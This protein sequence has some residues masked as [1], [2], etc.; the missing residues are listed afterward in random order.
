MKIEV[1]LPTSFVPN[2]MTVYKRTGSQPYI[3]CREDLKIY[4]PKGTDGEVR[5]TTVSPPPGGVFLVPPRMHG[6]S[7]IGTATGE[8]LLRVEGTVEEMVDLL[9]NIELETESHV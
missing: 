4:L 3:L 6:K 2:G 5:K 8:K 9:H 1:V 7:S